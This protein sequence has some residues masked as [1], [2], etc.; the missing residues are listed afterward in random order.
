MLL[1]DFDGT[2]SPIVSRPSGAVL[3]GKVKDELEKFATRYPAAVISGR[4]LKDVRRKVGIRGLAYA[5]SHGLVWQIGGRISR[6]LVTG[7]TAKNLAHIKKKLRH[8]PRVFP[9]VILENKDFGLA[10]HYRM[11]AAGK[12]AALKSFVSKEILP[13]MSGIRIQKGKKVVEFL[14][15]TDWNKGKCA[16][17][18]WKFFEK[19]TKR[20]LAPL[21]IGDDATDES[22]FAAL[23]RGVT[24]RVGR[25]ARSGAEYFIKDSS[26][27]RGLIA[28]LNKLGPDFQKQRE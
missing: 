14:P 6:V 15:D 26:R 9:G 21:Y 3:P 11:L 5:G 16:L 27:P 8:L 2:L 4:G 18:L 12:A 10:V 19:K 23:K 1:L 20:R 22:A 24:V 13:H 17:V 7:Q 28:L 25:S